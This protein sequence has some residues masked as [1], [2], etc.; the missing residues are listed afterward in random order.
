MIIS[1]WY[2]NRYIGAHKRRYY[3]DLSNIDD[4][5]VSVSFDAISYIPTPIFGRK[6]M[7]FSVLKRIGF[8]NSF[9]KLSPLSKLSRE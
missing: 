7:S 2:H 4:E 1:F 9:E 5:P 6:A 3:L 8:T